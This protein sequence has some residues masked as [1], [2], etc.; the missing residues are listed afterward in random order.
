MGRNGDDNHTLNTK[1]SGHDGPTKNSGKSRGGMNSRITM[2]DMKRRANNI[3]EYITRTQVELVHEPLSESKA[4]STR[5]NTED[6]AS[7]PPPV[8][9]K[10]NGGKPADQLKAASIM[11]NGAFPSKEFKELNCLEM[12]DALTRDLVKWQQ[13]FNP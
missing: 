8:E 5:S 3:L 1:G 11:A 6:G 9:V 13:E 4:N 12:M 7:A 10:I 2:T